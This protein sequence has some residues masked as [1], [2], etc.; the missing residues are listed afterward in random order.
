MKENR[1]SFEPLF[2]LYKKATVSQGCILEAWEKKRLW[3]PR[4]ALSHFHIILAFDVFLD[5]EVDIHSDNFAI[6]IP[7]YG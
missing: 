6:V 5:K 2:F 1:D 7:L 3:F 4:A